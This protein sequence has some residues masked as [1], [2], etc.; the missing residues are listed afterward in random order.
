MTCYIFG[1]GEYS[2]GAFSFDNDDFIIAADGGYETLEKLG[3]HPHMVVGDFDSCRSVP[4]H[5][6]L[7]HL[8][9]EKD[10]TDTGIAVQQGMA[11]GYKNFVIFGGTGGRFAHTMANIQLLSYLSM[12]GCRGVLVGTHEIM[13]TITSDKISFD[14]GCSG[15]LSLFS[16]SDVTQDVTIS[17]MKYELS[18]KILANFHSLGVSNEFIGRQAKISC[19]TGTLLII[20]ERR[21]YPYLKI[22]NTK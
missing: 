16:L 3:V 18:H 11:H 20:T 15:Y 8:S 5:E 14:A 7:L 9:P 10:D 19:G 13:T 22:N 6:N 17:G 1:A 2:G 21:N 4:E 12:N